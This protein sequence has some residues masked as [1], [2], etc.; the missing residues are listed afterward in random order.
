VCAV[1]AVPTACLSSQ[2]VPC[3]ARSVAVC[4]RAFGRRRY[5]RVRLTFA[6]GTRKV[7]YVTPKVGYAFALHGFERA[8]MR[9]HIP[10]VLLW[11]S[12]IHKGQGGTP[13]EAAGDL[14]KAF[15]VGQALFVMSQPPTL[16][17]LFLI[18]FD[19]GR[20]IVVDEAL[21][22]H[23]RRFF[24]SASLV[25]FRRFG[26]DTV[27]CPIGTAAYDLEWPVGDLATQLFGSD[28]MS[29]G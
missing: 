6:T 20:I 10:L 25:T 21:S 7:L 22:F 8:A 16:P 4:A 12:T 24:P 17:G 2:D 5:P 11:A 13:E 19:E 14:N 1:V 23:R 3:E 9:S 27:W 15:A 26:G 29:N 18:G 28:G